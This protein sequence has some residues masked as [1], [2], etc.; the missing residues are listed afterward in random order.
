[1]TPFFY[2]PNSDKVSDRYLFQGGV[3]SNTSGL[4]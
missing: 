2:D 1:M 3:L 4:S